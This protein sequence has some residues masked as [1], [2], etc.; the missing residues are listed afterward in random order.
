MKHFLMA[1]MIFLSVSLS[2][3]NLYAVDSESNISDCYAT[4]DPITGKLH[5]PCLDLGG[6][7]WADLVL[8]DATNLTFNF[9][10]GDI[11]PSIVQPRTDEEIVTA[12]VTEFFGNGDI[13]VAAKYLD[14]GY[15][16]HNP[17]SKNGRDAFVSGIEPFLP[18][19]K[20]WKIYRIISENGYVF[21]HSEAEIFG[22]NSAVGDLY[23]VVNGKIT[24][25]W[26]VTQEVPP[27]QTP[28]DNS[29]FTGPVPDKSVTS[30]VQN[31]INAAAGFDL[32]F[33]QRN[34][35][36]AKALTDE[37][38]IQHNPN[39]DNGWEAFQTRLSGFFSQAPDMHWTIKRVIGTGNFVVIH[40]QY[41]MP[42]DA[43]GN[44]NAEGSMAAF[45]IFRLDDTGKVAEHWDV[46]ETL[47]DPTTFAD[48]DT[49]FNGPGLYTG[50]QTPCP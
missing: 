1:V 39:T 35:E 6:L 18:Q 24:E 44:D 48:S 36:A 2:F 34:F 8:T 42:K 28:L 16:N 11:G 20:N 33:N 47:E 50:P 41:T 7:Y 22:A 49:Y 45:D 4:F 12:F 13:S 21:V 26:D 19:I 40:G 5:I 30:V 23:H 43:C 9:T 15:I 32:F 31:K 46:L 29:M 17:M 14:E 3:S 25:H 10:F 37:N 38:F 27:E